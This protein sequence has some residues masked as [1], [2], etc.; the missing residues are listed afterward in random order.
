MVHKIYQLTHWKR[1]LTCHI[2]VSCP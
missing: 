2:R 1:S